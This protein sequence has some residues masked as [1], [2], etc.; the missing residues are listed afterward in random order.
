MVPWR[1]TPWALIVTVEFFSHKDPCARTDTHR[2]RRQKEISTE[3]LI[4]ANQLYVTG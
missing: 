2:P 3:T 4:T 1:S